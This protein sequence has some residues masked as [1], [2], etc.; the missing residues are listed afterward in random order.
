MTLDE[1]REMITNDLRMDKTLLTEESVRIP[2]LIAK[3]MDLI[4]I[5][6][7]KKAELE[8]KYT[9]LLREK[10]VFYRTEYKLV[11]ETAKELQMLISGDPDVAQMK[12]HLDFLDATISHVEAAAKA[13]KDLVWTIKNII[14]WE[15]F[16]AG[17]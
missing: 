8:E 12:R 4:L 9:I 14:D 17:V 10:M 1:L 13:A 7:R 15:K 6:R 16:K 11:P 2:G 3:Y 5:T